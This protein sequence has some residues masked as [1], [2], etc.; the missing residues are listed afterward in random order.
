MSIQ[1]KN[2]YYEYCSGSTSG[3]LGSLRYP[4]IYINVPG[5]FWPRVNVTVRVSSIGKID[6]FKNYLYSMDTC[7]KKIKKQLHKNININV[8]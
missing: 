2:L 8:Q 7:A 4:F 3:N 1:L 6:Q 5:P